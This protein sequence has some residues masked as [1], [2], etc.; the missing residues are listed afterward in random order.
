MQSDLPQQFSQNHFIVHFLFQFLNFKSMPIFWIFRWLHQLSCSSPLLFSLIPLCS[1]SFYSSSIIFF[2][3]HHP[4]LLPSSPSSS[5]FLFPPLSPCI[6]FSF[7][8]LL[9]PLVLHEHGYIVKL[10]SHSNSL[11]IV[12]SLNFWK[13]QIAIPRWNCRA[14]VLSD[15][16][17]IYYIWYMK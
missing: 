13:Y 7:S 15:G 6:H 8:F 3:C 4:S 11:R 9:P 5:S 1:S 2:F 12:I 16:S 17:L 14:K 10:D